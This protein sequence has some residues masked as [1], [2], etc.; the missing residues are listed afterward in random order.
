MQ[1]IREIGEE[2]RAYIM[3]PT[4]I[5]LPQ[6]YYICKIQMSTMLKQCKNIICHSNKCAMLYNVQQT[7]SNGSQGELSM[8]TGF[9]HKISMPNTNMKNFVR[10][11]RMTVEVNIVYQLLNASEISSFLWVPSLPNRGPTIYHLHK[12]L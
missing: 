8:K 6:V 4:N 5:F 9:Q 12:M 3:S 7:Y 10:A 2:K 11:T 1:R